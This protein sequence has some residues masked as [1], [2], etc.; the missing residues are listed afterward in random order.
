[1]IRTA[2]LS[3]RRVEGKL[4]GTEKS[5]LDAWLGEDSPHCVL[6]DEMNSDEDQ[7]RLL[8]ESRA[9]DVGFA[10]DRGRYH[11]KIAQKAASRKKR[12]R[13]WGAAALMLVLIGSGLQYFIGWRPRQSF[14]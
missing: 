13:V 3:T 7:M 9:I 11:L 1:M 2:R 6:F 4:E 8:E 5:E 14:R 10:L 12:T